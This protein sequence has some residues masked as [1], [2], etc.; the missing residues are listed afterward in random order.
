MELSYTTYGSGPA[1]VL[2]HSGG[3]DSR[4][5][6][7]LI[8][9]LARSHRVVTYDARGTG[10]SPAPQEPIDLIHDLS[11]LLDHLQLDRVTL[12]GHSIGGEVATNFTL[13]Y[14]E[15]AQHLIVVAP[16]LTGFAFS[17]TYTGWMQQLNSLAPD[18]GRMIQFSLAGPIYQTVMAS[19][20]RD[21]FIEM[22]T[23]YFTRVFT[24]WR[25]FE[26]IWPQPPAVERL[27]QIAVPVLFVDGTVEWS[28]MSN[29]AEAFKR[30]PRTAFARLEG[31]DHMI[32][33]THAKEL[34]AHIRSFLEA[35]PNRN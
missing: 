3:V 19:D 9:L 26:L 5:W 22:H 24:E 29:I 1:I 16:S 31:A 8:P 10:R 23:E 35:T 15:R 18:I 27:E 21:F 6:L 20:Y 30:V 32:P 14:P 33:L 28:D 7:E 2:I 34:A 25:S 4:E 17:D 11:E 12:V 13:S